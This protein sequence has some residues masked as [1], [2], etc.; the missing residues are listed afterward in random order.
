VEPRIKTEQGVRK[1]DIVAKLG[2]TAVVLDAQIVNDQMDLDG[3]HQ[4]KVE[5]YTTIENEI[6]REYDVENAIFSS[7]TL[8]WRGFWSRASVEHLFGLGVLKKRQR[9]FRQGPSLVVWPVSICSTRPRTLEDARDDGWRGYW[10]REVVRSYLSYRHN[11][12]SR[13]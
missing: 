1:P 11:V 5:Y 8:S 9:S 4:K 13:T 2:I 12:M 7:I 3:A 10:R 6:K